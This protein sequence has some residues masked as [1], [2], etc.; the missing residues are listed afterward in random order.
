LINDI[1]G[2]TTVRNLTFNATITATAGTNAGIVFISHNGAALQNVLFNTIMESRAVNAS[3]LHHIHGTAMSNVIF[4][5]NFSVGGT[6]TGG[7]TAS[8]HA[9]G[10]GT[11]TDVFVDASVFGVGGTVPLGAADATSRTRQQI[12]DAINAGGTW[13][14]WEVVDGMYRLR[15]I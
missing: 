5:T 3:P 12:I 2:A 13:T 7:Q 15:M 14:N 8:A 11:R 6:L 10:A 9:G 1:H 4:A